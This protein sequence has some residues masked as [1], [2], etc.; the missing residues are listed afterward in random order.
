MNSCFQPIVTLF[1]AFQKGFVI[2]IPV[3]YPSS[4]ST[5][6]HYMVI[7]ILILD[8][9]WPWHTVT[10]LLLYCF[11]ALLLYCFTALL[12]YCSTK[13]LTTLRVIF[14]LYITHL[15]PISRAFVVSC[16]SNAPVRQR[17]DRN[18]HQNLI[19]QRT[20]YRRIMNT[21]VVSYLLLRK[22]SSAVCSNNSLCSASI[23]KKIIV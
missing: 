17:V 19:P 14:V 7:R 13:I 5:T 4:S 8:S 10:S 3:V 22:F 16:R 2:V 6:I 18:P 9:C 15:T 23:F 21:K 12:L 1:Q 20:T 11:T